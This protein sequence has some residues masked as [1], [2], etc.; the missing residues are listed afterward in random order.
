MN[1]FAS[2]IVNSKN[3][4]QEEETQGASTVR[5]RHVSKPSQTPK[6]T[7]VA[8]LSKPA[9]ANGKVRILYNIMQV[10]FEC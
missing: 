10:S 1:V 8:G 2:C 4:A 6:P 5:A 7:K 9:K 3:R